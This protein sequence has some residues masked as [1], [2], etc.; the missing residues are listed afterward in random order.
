GAGALGP[1]EKSLADYM[2]AAAKA[3]RDNDWESADEVWSKMS[4]QNSKYYL[5]IGPDEVYW[6]PCSQKAGF[7]VTFARINKES[8]GWQQ[9]LVPL[10]QNMEADLAK[11]IGAP[12]RERKV[13]FHLPDFIEIIL[14]AGDDRHAF[15]ATIGQSLPNWGKVA[16]ESRGR[17]VAM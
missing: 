16:N 7:H 1:D 5:R 13:S 10:Q 14:N 6:E 8:L 4:S 15:G 2:R 3:F 12:Y 9:K 11:L 17:T